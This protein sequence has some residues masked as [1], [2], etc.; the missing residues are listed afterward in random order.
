M[1]AR[2]SSIAATSAL[3]H[4]PNTPGPPDR[5]DRTRFTAPGRAAAT[6][7]FGVP[8]ARPRWRRPVSHGYSATGIHRRVSGVSDSTR[9]SR[10]LHIT[11]PPANG[12]TSLTGHG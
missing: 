3:A 2:S 11:S 1:L 9:V 8:L 10:F 6:D 5:V 12:P 4:S 7:G